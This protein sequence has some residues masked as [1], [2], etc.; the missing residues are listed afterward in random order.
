MKSFKECQD[1]LRERGLLNKFYRNFYE[2]MWDDRFQTPKDVYDE[3]LEAFI[4]NAFAW[5]ET[6]EYEQN[7]SFWRDISEEFEIWF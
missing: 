5:M 4:F 3:S 7:N 1:W 2:Q 6:P